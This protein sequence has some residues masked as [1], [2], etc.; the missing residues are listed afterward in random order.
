MCI[1]KWDHL[2]KHWYGD[3]MRLP[4]ISERRSPHVPLIVDFENDYVEHMKQMSNDSMK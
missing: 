1:K 2:L 3:Y 4:P